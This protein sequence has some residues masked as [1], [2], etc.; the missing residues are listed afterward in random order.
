MACFVLS[1]QHKVGQVKKKSGEAGPV[2][3]SAD[4][5]CKGDGRDNCFIN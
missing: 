1:T 3:T 5:K 2:I 4:L